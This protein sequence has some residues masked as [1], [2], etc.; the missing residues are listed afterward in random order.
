MLSSDWDKDLDIPSTQILLTNA[1]TSSSRKTNARK[2]FGKSSTEEA[3]S[4]DEFEVPK[5]TKPSVEF[6]KWSGSQGVIKKTKVSS[7]F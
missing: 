5:A 4:E 6:D 1:L 3:N 2:T 7:T